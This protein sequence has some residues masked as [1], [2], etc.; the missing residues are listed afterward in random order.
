MKD[1]KVPLVPLLRTVCGILVVTVYFTFPRSAAL[2]TDT[3]APW[4]VLL[5]GGLAFLLVWPVL[6]G[7]AQQPGKNL[8]DLALQAGGRPV[9]IAQALLLGAYLTT[10]SGFTVRQVSEM[11]VTA[12]FPHT[13]QTFAMS[14]LLLVGAMGAAVRPRSAL[15]IGSLFFVPILVVTAVVLVGDV[16][17]GQ[18]RNAMPPTGYGLLPTM[19]Q[20]FPLTSYFDP[21][22]LV[23]IFARFL[24]TP[25]RL[26]KGTLLSMSVAVIT[27]ALVTL[28]Y[29]M[30]FP[31][32]GGLG[33]PFP[34]FEMSRLIQG[35]RFLERTDVF[36][37]VFWTFG[38]A[39]RHSATLMASG[40][41][42]KEAFR[43][44]THRD[45]VLPLT[46]AALAVALVPSNQAAAIDMDTFFVHRWGF[47][48]DL[49]MPLA[50]ALVARIRTGGGKAG[51]GKGMPNA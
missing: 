38:A 17:W 51:H 48:V 12:L 6:T 32:P 5:S 37:I 31:L 30:V 46:A 33:I 41:L 26:V 47:L 45:T 23:A 24:R 14:S 21:L 40:I 1:E 11:V 28:L 8:T 42:F 10:A 39:V 15:W 22:I 7:L 18:L 43:L 9:A 13:P 29:I 44:P 34:M 16:G 25:S 35:G 20:L 49:V 36:W 27:W 4:T 19:M 50:I 2:M 3:A